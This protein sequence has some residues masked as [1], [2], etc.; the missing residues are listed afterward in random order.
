MKKL[1]NRVIDNKIYYLFCSFKGRFD[2]RDVAVKRISLKNYHLADREVKLYQKSDQHKNIVRYF[3][4]QIH[5]DFVYLAIELCAASL[6]DWVIDKNEIRSTLKIQ[7]KEIMCQAI[8]GLDHFHSLNLVHRDIKPHNI[9]LSLPD[10][11]NK[12]LVKISDFGLSRHIEGGK[13]FSNTSGIMGTIGWIAPEILTGQ[14]MVSF[15]S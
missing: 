11:N 9:L 3:I 1:L 15:C 2:N 7:A 12:V 6:Q 10:H 8:I 14:R 4:S 5:D 13:S